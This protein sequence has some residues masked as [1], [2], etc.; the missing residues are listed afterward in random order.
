MNK[1]TQHQISTDDLVSGKQLVLNFWDNI[2]MTKKLFQRLWFI[3][4]YFK[5]I[6]L[7]LSA[8]SDIKEGP[9]ER[10]NRINWIV[11]HHAKRFPGPNALREIHEAR[12]MLGRFITFSYNAKMNNTLVAEE[13][14][15]ALNL[16]EKSYADILRKV[17]S[18]FAWAYD[19][20]IPDHIRKL[21]EEK[22]P[23]ERAEIP[24]SELEKITDNDL[25]VNKSYRFHLIIIIDN[26]LYM[27][28]NHVLE[29]L[30]QSLT[31]LEHEI[32]RSSELSRRVELYVAT[33]GGGATEIVDFAMIERQIL[34][35]DQL[36]LR[37][38]G[39][40]CMAETINK[41]LDKLQISLDKLNDPKCDIKYYRPWML[42][43]TNG[44]FKD[45]MKETMARITRDFG[46]IQVYARG[47]TPDANMDKLRTLDPDAAILDSLE[48]F[49]KDV[50]V[51]LRRV[52]YSIPGG[53]RIHLVNQS[54]F[55]K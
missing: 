33:C 26:G 20:Q 39:R 11:S 47:L 55:T 51:S 37:P 19:L 25:E 50:F 27:G 52:K 3:N 7:D 24:A 17:S 42:V 49:F 46:F 14:L 13:D 18:F 28:E 15:E 45:D 38:Y 6:I 23:K 35:L 36:I 12:N 53:E 44:N 4:N 31:T 5:R 43:L 32:N 41:S 8:D 30:Q 40:C 9:G 29:K 16:N 2:D 22:G 34:S 10:A 48:G 1:T 54:G 21:Y